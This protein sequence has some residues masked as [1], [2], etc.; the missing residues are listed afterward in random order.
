MKTS[1]SHGLGPVRRPP[2]CSLLP[3]LVRRPAVSREE[4]APAEGLWLPWLLQLTKNVVHISRGCHQ[5]RTSRKPAR[6]P[7]HS[8]EN[9][10]TT[11]PISFTSP[12]RGKVLR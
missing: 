4:R 3:H 8:S 1:G 7:K 2:P 9:S 11:L 6:L 12:K 10:R 5:G